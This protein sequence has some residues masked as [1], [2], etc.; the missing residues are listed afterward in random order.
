MRPYEKP[1]PISLIASVSKNNVIG[2]KGQ[3]PW[4]I[5]EDLKHFKDLTVGKMV[6][7]GQNT[8]ESL[9]EKVRPLPGRKNIV[10]TRTPGY[11]V[12]PDVELFFDLDQA[13]VT[14]AND[15]LMIMGGAMIY[16][17]TINRADRLYITHV[18]RVVEGDAT[19]PTIDPD[20]WR[21]IAHEDRDGFS[22]VTYERTR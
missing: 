10:V 2:V 6:L 12:P 11:T 20:V 5:P 7:M 22:F 19:F 4:H 14:H 1:M 8:W 3:L 21:E 17:Q 15:D 13:L 16:H 9:P 18:N